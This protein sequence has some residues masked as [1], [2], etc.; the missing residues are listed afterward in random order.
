MAA[1]KVETLEQLVR[2]MTLDLLDAINEVEGVDAVTIDVH[3]AHGLPSIE[4]SA[5]S[6]GHRVWYHNLVG[7]ELPTREA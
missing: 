3:N 2:G 5:W 1:S 7:D 4:Y 6:N